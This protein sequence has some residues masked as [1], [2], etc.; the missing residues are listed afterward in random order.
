MSN[1]HVIVK[2]VSNDEWTK[3]ITSSFNKNVKE[4]SVEGFRKGKC[5]RNIYE[6]KYGVESLFNDAINFVLPNVYSEILKE[7]KLIPVV[8]PSIDIKNIDKDSVEFEFTIITAPEVKIK[9]YKKLDVKKEKVKVTKEDIKAEIDRIRDQYAEI[10]LKDG[11]IENGDTVVIDFEGFKDEVAFEGGK[12]E[13]YPLEI[14]SNTFIPGFE[15]Q[16]IGS[17]TNDKKEIKVTF[18]EDY[19]NDDLKNKEVLFKVTIHEV[20]SRS[21][22]EINEDFFKD[23]NINGINSL[24]E[25][26]EYCENNLKEKKE[27]D[28][29]SK[30]VNDILE[31][32][33]KETK[34]E[35]PEELVH[36]EIHH[37]IDNYS[38]KLQMQGL[39]LDQFLK[40]TKS[41]IEDMEKQLDGEAKKNL[42]YRYMIEE[43]SKIENID[44]DDKEV[45]KEAERL[46]ELYQMEKE[47]LINTFGGL[48]MIKYDLKIRKTIDFIKENN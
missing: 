27:K 22:P 23:L 10:V 29:D 45:N 38:Q 42:T 48:D 25:F 37:M 17:K 41:T 26:E 34:I 44:V 9:K 36:E 19:P 4:V 24:K 5:P 32:I 12:G 2:K 6:K 13:N 28:L 15:S 8:Q 35:L 20:K 3:A 46:A 7:S 14:G 18:P 40:M 16:L 47:E 21:I 43:I 11:K 30:F 31:S 33:A 1:K 39:S